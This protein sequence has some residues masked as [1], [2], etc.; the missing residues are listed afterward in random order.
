MTPKLRVNP[1][2]ILDAP[3]AELANFALTTPI[4]ALFYLV[5]DTLIMR[6]ER[7]ALDE[8]RSQVA[9][10]EE[11][12]DR[13][14]AV[15]RAC[16]D[17]AAALD[18]VGRQGGVVEMV[19]DLIMAARDAGSLPALLDYCAEKKSLQSWYLPNAGLHALLE[20]LTRA[21]PAGLREHMNILPAWD[22]KAATG[23]AARLAGIVKV[24]N[25]GERVSRTVAA[26]LEFCD[27]VILWD[28]A[29]ND[30]SIDD[31]ERAMRDGHDRL[32]LVRS[33]AS[34]YNERIIYDGLFARARARGATHICHFDADEVLAATLSPARVRDMAAG[35]E[36]GDTACIELVQLVG[37][38]G[39]YIDYAGA[40][41]CAV[42]QH[43]LPQ[44]RDFLF[45]DD[46]KSVHA[47]APLHGGWLP[48]GTLR[49]R[50]FIDPAVAVNFHM[51]KPDRAT[52]H[53]KND[54][55]KA[56]E[57]V[58]HGF[59]VE[60]LVY[61]YMFYALTYAYLDKNT[62]TRAPTGPTMDAAIEATRTA[63]K[64]ADLRQWL[65]ELRTPLEKWLF[66]H[67]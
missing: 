11:S 47:Q 37:T 51:D 49:R 65:G 16:G 28:H 8:L 66:F 39:A 42:A 19:P 2:F 4:D 31:L 46:G 27:Y 33:T 24:H 64:A 50:R 60:K 43:Y 58:L 5:L 30:G 14:F 45:A 15:I 48:E 44:W 3:T 10:E 1:D 17:P 6:G 62:G 32:E 67:A 9:D 25:E 23:K 40:G 34:E 12:I 53:I 57:L 38:Q 29:S 52:A 35:L 22:G 63:E 55:Y 26:M 61:R 21:A 7:A 36:P 41:G 18:L 56:K 59:P 54:W 13:R 20:Q